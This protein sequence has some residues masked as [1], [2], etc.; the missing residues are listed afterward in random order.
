MGF[1]RATVT[2]LALLML[3]GCHHEQRRGTPGVN[4]SLASCCYGWYWNGFICQPLLGPSNC[5]CR[6][7]IP[8][9][10]Y[11]SQEECISDHPG[12]PVVETPLA[13]ATRRAAAGGVSRS[14]GRRLVIVGTV[15]DIT[16]IDDGFKPWAITVHVEKVVTGQLLGDRLT[17]LVHS[18]ARAGLAVGHTY[19]VDAVWED[20]GYSVDELQ[21]LRRGDMM[22]P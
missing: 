12:S 3:A 20:G 7:Q 19:T 21:W 11:G 8:P 2:G 22:S 18:P 1:V 16:M 10:P 5:G 9:E 13:A 14:A 6:C 17:F 4:C 15:V